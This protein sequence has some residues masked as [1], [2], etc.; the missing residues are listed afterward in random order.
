M[1][2]FELRRGP[3]RRPPDRGSSRCRRRPRSAPEGEELGCVGAG[4][5]APHADHRRRQ[6]R[7]RRAGPGRARSARTAGPDRPPLPAPSQGS[8]V[9]GSS[10]RG[11]QRVDQRD[12][13]GPAL[14]GGERD[15]GRVGRCSA[16][17]SRSAASRSAGGAPRRAPASPPAARRRS[18]RTSTFGH[19]TLSSIA[20]TS[21]RPPTPST[22]RAKPSRSVAITETISGTGSSAS[23]GRSCG[24]EPLEAL[25]R[26]PDRVDHPARR[27]IEPRRRVARAGLR[28][29][30]LRDEGARTGSARAARRRTRAARRSRRRCRSRSG[31]GA[32][33]QRPPML[34][35]SMPG[36][37]HERGFDLVRPHHGPVDAEPHV[38]ARP[39]AG[40]RSRSRRRSRR[41]SAP[42]SRA[43]PG[44]PRSAQ[45]E[46]DR[47]EHRRR[48]ARVDGGAAAASSPLSAT[49]SRSVT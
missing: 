12:R 4:F 22:R 1:Q 21:S 47:L 34:D 39:R 16:S 20:A 37:R 15:R 28:G 3:V 19:E 41:P 5:D 27:L 29:D 17:A 33:A 26:E 8:P 13:V 6:P 7:P 10:A 46:P 40:P 43:R 25:V 45:I 49:W 44:T 32:R 42:P 9:P 24:E 38:A 2:R 23:C 30:R 48:A 35:S 18:D 31:P 36:P 14:L 11:A